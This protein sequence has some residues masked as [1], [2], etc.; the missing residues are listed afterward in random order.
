MGAAQGN[1]DQ[2]VSTC[3]CGQPL[4]DFPAAFTRGMCVDC[5]VK[6]ATHCDAC[7]GMRAGRCVV[8][9][10][11]VN[12]GQDEHV[13]RLNAVSAA[14]PPLVRQLPWRHIS[15][16]EMM[17]YFDCRHLHG[18]LRETSQRFQALATA[19]AEDGALD[20]P[21]L[22]VA[23]RKLLEAKDAAVRAALPKP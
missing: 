21:E 2:P 7:S 4:A 22:T 17:R 1:V 13:K 15:V 19:L 6:A 5:Y 18:S 11:V 23:L 14:T 8:C 10:R 12:P 3:E 9:N 20:G 16:Q